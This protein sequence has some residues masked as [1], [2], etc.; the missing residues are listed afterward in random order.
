MSTNVLVAT[1]TVKFLT[2]I[3]STTNDILI[4]NYIPMILED[5]VNYT[6]NY[7]I[8]STRYFYDDKISFAS[9]GAILC[10]NT[11]ID[12]TDFLMSGS[13]FNISGS[14]WNDGYFSCSTSSSLV[15]SSAI[16]VNETVNAE[17][18]STGKYILLYRVE[19]PK[20]LPL[21]AS[22]MIKHL[23]LSQDAENIQSE[24][25]GDHSISYA[26]IGSNSYP[27]SIANSLNKYRKMIGS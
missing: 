16:Y 11:A 3:S 24:S 8:Q 20:D 4:E 12:F 5:I 26:D 2:G 9:S 27:V 6:H 15:L 22:R 23:I 17:T 14:V 18:T 13:V 19:Y 1:S 10:N 21:I 25:L 7:F